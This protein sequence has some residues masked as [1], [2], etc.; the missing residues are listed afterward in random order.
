MSQIL[1]RCNCASALSKAPAWLFGLHGAGDPPRLAIALRLAPRPVA[2][3]P[4]GPFLDFFTFPWGGSQRAPA[5]RP[6]GLRVL[7]PLVQVLQL[8]GAGPERRVAADHLVP[9]VRGLD[10]PPPGRA[11]PAAVQRRGVPREGVLRET[12]LPPRVHRREDLPHRAREVPPHAPA[13]RR[14]APRRAPR[15]PA[16]RPRNA[17]PR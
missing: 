1:R 9:F 6:R 7:R 4:G 10:V 3:A 12:H 5:R 13:A 2:R 17:P 16:P 14:R 8:R 11:R 15:H